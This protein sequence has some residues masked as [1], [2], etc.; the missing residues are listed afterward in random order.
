MTGKQNSADPHWN[1]AILTYSG[2]ADIYGTS[3]KQHGYFVNQHPNGDTSGGTFEA[4]VT[5]TEGLPHLEGTWR[6]SFGTGTLKGVTGDGRFAASMN[7]RG[8]SEMAWSG[9]YEL[10]ST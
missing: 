9:A 5:L 8:E 7:A 10:L 3:G 6:L 1:S 4:T 2:M